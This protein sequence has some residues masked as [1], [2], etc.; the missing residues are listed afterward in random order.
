MRKILSTIFIIM[1]LICSMSL[2]SCEAIK[3]QNINVDSLSGMN[4]A[5]R[6]QKD[7]G[8]SENS[9]V[10]GSPDINRNIE[11]Y[12]IIKTDLMG[13]IISVDGNIITIEL[14]EQ[15]RNKTSHNSND[16]KQDTKDNQNSDN[17][18]SQNSFSSNKFEI[19]YTGIYKTIEVS[20]YVGIS[21]KLNIENQTQN[22]DSESPI[23]VSDLK[24]DQIIM[25]WYQ[26]NSYTVEKINV[27]QS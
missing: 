7:P 11:M 21:Q 18:N 9:K 13:K 10:S 17:N 5:P 26:K 4:R 14:I 16:D 23:K 27:I 12:G 24:K 22:S 6:I 8:T 25:A 3:S 1:L 20:D 19:N 2:I 15:T